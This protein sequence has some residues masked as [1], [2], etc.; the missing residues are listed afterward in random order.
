[1][2]FDQGNVPKNM[3]MND[4]NAAVS[5]LGGFARSCRFMAVIEP[6]S[7]ALKRFLPKND[8]HYM[9]D[10]V[11]FPG[12]GFG[13]QEARYYG[14][15]I[16]TPNNMEFQAANFSFLCRVGSIE[17]EFF[18]NWLEF[19]N[20]SGSFNFSYPTDYYSTVTIY[21][22]GEAPAMTGANTP[23]RT[24]YGLSATKGSVPEVVYKWRLLRAWPIV[25]SAQQA[26]WA[27]QEVLRLQVTF[28]Y[29][30]WDRPGY[31]KL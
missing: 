13:L 4:V 10:A 16:A 7:D 14:P 22:L 18:D 19:I 20:P 27:D 25:V 15:S 17:R 6:S 5:A 3:K 21:Q 11:E 23:Q 12:K 2:A 30:N 28:T 8:L 29:R 24:P 1:M 9:C 26:T 31:N